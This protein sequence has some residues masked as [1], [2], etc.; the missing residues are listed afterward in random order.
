MTDHCYNQYNIHVLAEGSSKL[1][2]TDTVLTRKP[3]AAFG[4]RTFWIEHQRPTKPGKSTGNDC[5][6]QEQ[7]MTDEIK[8]LNRK[9]SLI[10]QE[11]IELYKK[12]DLVRQEN[13]ELRRKVYG[14]ENIDEANR[15][16][17]ITDGIN[18]E[19]DLHAPIN[20]QL[21]QPQTQKNNTPTIMMKLG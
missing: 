4:R 5:Q 10:H 3:Q 7:I 2:E 11:N 17:H 12:V 20:L 16:S 8:E 6:C 13:A 15:V 18:N 19:Y 21:S 14:S 9:G 1:E